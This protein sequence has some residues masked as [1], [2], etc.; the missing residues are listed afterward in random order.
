M[1]EKQ[2]ESRVRINL[3]GQRTTPKPPT[4]RSNE[5]PVSRVRINPRSK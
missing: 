1:T 5:K 4:P 2:P 3:T